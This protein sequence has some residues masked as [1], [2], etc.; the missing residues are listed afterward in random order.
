MKYSEIKKKTT[1][2]PIKKSLS[3]L[4]G[5][6]AIQNIRAKSGPS[7]GGRSFDPRKLD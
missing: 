7:T 3:K 6:Q 2:S 5:K 1:T 4:T